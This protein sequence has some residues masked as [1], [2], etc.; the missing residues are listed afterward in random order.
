MIHESTSV[1]LRNFRVWDAQRA[2][3]TAD[4]IPDFNF[5][6]FLFSRLLYTNY[7]IKALAQSLKSI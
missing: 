2:H 4:G 1:F 3:Q 6:N 7:I 5:N